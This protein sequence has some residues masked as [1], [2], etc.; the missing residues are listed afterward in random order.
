MKTCARM[1]CFE[2]QCPCSKQHPTPTEISRNQNTSQFYSKVSQTLEVELNKQHDMHAREVDELNNQIFVLKNTVLRLE[3][4]NHKDLQGEKELR[5]EYN[6]LVGK[7]RQGEPQV[8]KK[9][10]VIEKIKEIP[11]EIENNQL[12]EKQIAY[13]KTKNNE[14]MIQLQKTRTD[15]EVL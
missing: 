15:K 12:W 13:W 2:V 14:M 5:R 6:L 4:R 8:I 3:M 9:V 11:V 1:L 10:E 7:L